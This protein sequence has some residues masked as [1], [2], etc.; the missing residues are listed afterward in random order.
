MWLMSY[1][2]RSFHRSENVWIFFAC[3][4]STSLSLCLEYHSRNERADSSRH[5][6]VCEKHTAELMSKSD[7]ECKVDQGLSSSERVG[8]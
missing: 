7:L 4:E 6:I 2:H 3:S 8:S 5:S 1:V